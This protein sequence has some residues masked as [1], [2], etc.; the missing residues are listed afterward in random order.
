MYTLDIIRT[1]TSPAGTYGD[2]FIF[3]NDNLKYTCKTLELPWRNNQRN[4]SCIP[5]GLYKGIKHQSP[6]FGKCFKIL[7]VANRSHILIH[8]ANYTRQLQG[9]IAIGQRHIDIDGDG[10]KDITSSKATL[11][12]LLEI[13]PDN[14][15]INIINA[16]L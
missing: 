15:N 13:L 16:Y 14:I 4:I 8:P 11:N 5:E 12:E 6:K 3:N 1:E 9:C 10:I 7:N 2:L